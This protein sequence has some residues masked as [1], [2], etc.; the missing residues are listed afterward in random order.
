[1]RE[2]MLV[3]GPAADKGMSLNKW[4]MVDASGKQW[5]FLT[6]YFREE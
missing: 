6:S 5:L 2:G 1:M 4:V 3:M